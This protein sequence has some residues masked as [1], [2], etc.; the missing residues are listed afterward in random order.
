ME[1]SNHLKNLFIVKLKKILMLL[2]IT[3]KMLS[4]INNLLI[5][6]KYMQEKVLVTKRKYFKI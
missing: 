2:S 6:L 3:Y 1:T 4:N 5:Y